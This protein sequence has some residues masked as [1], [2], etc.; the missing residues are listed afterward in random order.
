MQLV[1]EWNRGF[2][3]Q[4]EQL[5]EL[6]WKDKGGLRQKYVFSGT[7]IKN[8]MRRPP[9]PRSYLDKRLSKR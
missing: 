7:K 6:G 9:K 8:M 5:E 3:E 4:L 2:R 1:K